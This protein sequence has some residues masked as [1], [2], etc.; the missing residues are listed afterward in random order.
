MTG[1]VRPD[2]LIDEPGGVPDTAAAALPTSSPLVRWAL[3]AGAVGFLLCVL[4]L[5]LVMV[6]LGAFEQGWR[7]AAAALVDP[8]A[9]AALRLTG[10]VVVIV[11]PANIVFGIAAAW[12]LTKFRLPGRNLL[13]TFIDLPISVSPV[14]A[15]MLF[16]LLF[17]KRGLLGP[18]LLEHNLPIIYAVPG[19]VLATLF[20]TLPYVAR[21]LI[22]LMQAQ[23]RDE[24]EAAVSLGAGGW[25]TFLRVTLPNIKWGLVYGT[26]LCG[27]RALGEF[28]AVSVVSGHIRGETNTLPLHV[29]VLYNEYQFAAAFSVAGLLVLGALATIVVKHVVEWRLQRTWRRRAATARIGRAGYRAEE[30]A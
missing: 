5:P 10:L 3:I 18:W 19:I 20:V 14:I 22:P 15:G 17:G 9:L 2:V 25:A 6:I 27:A 24:E 4:V 7:A 28:G 16:V 13:I 23:G 8:D 30:A 21:E 26:I 11:V 1:D 12:A 29:E